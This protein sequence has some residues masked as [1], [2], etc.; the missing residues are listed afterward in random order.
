MST[1][2]VPYVRD[3]AESSAS[4]SSIGKLPE[5]NKSKESVSDIDS[6]LPP[7]EESARFTDILFPRRRGNAQ[8]IDPDAIATRRSVFDDPKLAKHYM[9]TEKYENIH[10]FDPNARWT[11]REERVCCFISC[12]E[13]HKLNAVCLYLY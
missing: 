13:H 10:R 7:V 9:P 8:L 4:T 6:L 11:F 12:T 1:P 3:R 5:Q 2:T